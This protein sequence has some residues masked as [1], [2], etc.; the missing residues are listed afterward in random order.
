MPALALILGMTTAAHVLAVVGIAC[1]LILL[2]SRATMRPTERMMRERR[3]HAERTA[4]A[5]RRMSQIRAE[6]IRRMDEA[7]RRWRP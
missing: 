1:I 6:T 3:R 2:I 5:I 7:E 4:R